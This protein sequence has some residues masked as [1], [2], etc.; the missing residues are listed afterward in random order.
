MLKLSALVFLMGTRYE[1]PA[2]V[3][4]CYLLYCYE[5][6]RLHIMNKVSNDLLHKG[7][8]LFVEFGFFLPRDSP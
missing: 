1:L 7:G 4:G 5:Y 8:I 6:V 3:S 2:I